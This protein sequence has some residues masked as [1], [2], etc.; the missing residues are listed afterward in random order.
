VG[1]IAEVTY[2]FMHVRYIQRLTWVFVGAG[3][4][5]LAIMLVFMLGDYLTRE[6]LAKPGF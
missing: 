1:F 3:F 4:F 5:L 6:V 2:Y